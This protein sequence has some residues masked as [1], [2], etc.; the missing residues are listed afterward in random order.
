MVWRRV[1]ARLVQRVPRN[2]V[3]PAIGSAGSS[4][5]PLGAAWA[6]RT[7][8]VRLA[9]G[10][11]GG[12][13]LAVWMGGVAVELDEARSADPLG[14]GVSGARTTA[15]VYAAVCRAFNRRLVIDI[16]AGASAG[17]LNGAFLAGVI[18]HGKRLEPDFLRGRWLDIGDFGTL[19]QPIED[20]KPVSIMQGG[21]FLEQLEQAFH[22]L[23]RTNDAPRGD[24]EVP[25]LLDVQVTNVVGQERCFVDDWGQSFYAIEYRAPM[26]FREWEHYTA[27]FLATAARASASFPGAFESQQ[28]PAALAVLGGLG[29]HPTWAIDGGLLEN[30]PIRPAIELIPYRQASGPVR[31]Y[32]CYVN[33]APT[34][35]H[36]LDKSRGQP[37]LTKVLGYTINLPR[38]GRVVDQL[39][40]LD[41][42]TRRTGLT[43]DAGLRLLAVGVE[44][45]KE[46]ATHLLPTYQVRRALLS[47]ENVLGGS[48]GSSGPGL[49]R[50]TL[51]QLTEDAGAAPGDLAAGSALL[52]WI[53]GSVDPPA[54]PVVWR[55]G[56]RTGQRVIQ[57]QLDVLRALLLT[58]TSPEEAAAVFSARAELDTAIVQL[59]PTL[60]AFADPKGGV[61]TAARRL[62]SDNADV[63]R[64]ALTALGPP[65]HGAAT[66]V[67]EHLRRSTATFYATLRQLGDGALKRANLPSR[68][69]LFGKSLPNELDDP[70]YAA[71][72]ALA[73]PIEVIRRSFADDF[74]IETAQALHV[75]QLTPLVPAP[76]FDR[77]GSGTTER[78][79]PQ[80][81]RDKLAGVRLNHFAGFYRQSW[82]ANDFMWGRFDGATV[83]ARLLID[84]MRVRALAAAGGQP[85][86]DL[87]D[88]LVPSKKGDAGSAAAKEREELLEELLPAGTD[89][90][91]E[92]LAEALR[93]DL[94]EQDGELTRAVVARALQYAI[95]DTE[96][97][98]LLDAV[99]ADRAAGAYRCA[100]D[101]PRTGSRKQVIDDLRK[102]RDQRSLPSILGAGDP[103]E[104][105]S[106]LALRTIS[107]TVLVALAALTGIVPLAR[108]LH[109]ARVPFLAIRGATALRRLDRAAVVLGF[110]GAAWFVAARLLTLSH[111]TDDQGA[112]DRRATDLVPLKALWSSPVLAYGVSILAVLALFSIPLIR[113]IRAGQNTK[114]RVFHGSYALG[115]LLAGG[116]VVFGYQLTQR[117]VAQVL[118]TWDSPAIAPQWLLI[119]VVT[120]GAVQVAS[121]FGWV[122]QLLGFLH[123]PIKNR[124]SLTSLVL[125]LVA[126][127]LAYY[128][129]RE[130]FVPTWKDGTWQKVG[131]VLAG[132]AP[133][134][135]FLYLRLWVGEPKRAAPPSRSSP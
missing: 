66:E 57:L 80:T 103:S 113:T 20:T 7:E 94:L 90:L 128:C 36:E 115:F 39:Q 42:A 111:P 131:I 132:L 18:A 93:R 81:T 3:V 123:R 63:R 32:V 125:G 71:F 33:A 121:S 134:L 65:T 26:K 119:S 46:T 77:D 106:Q 79:G 40:A 118:T 64:D 135:A 133:V 58:S 61:A 100:L 120:A 124:V 76:L 43:A 23:L 110:T 95:L 45:L 29:P 87:A 13:S 37:N 59:E 105:T 24:G 38:D 70:G 96:I 122:L 44:G 102:G 41:D 53:P 16:L 1:L 28:I 51:N 98:F 11:N 50:S 14:P 97:P 72:L 82:R 107:H 25:V 74:D 67:G 69:E 68:Q 30:A 86:Q 117:S 109:P 55:W 19:L 101:W 78:L 114:R 56:V 83:I 34:S 54:E 49:A 4:T 2:E 112:L 60:R 92:R 104:G 5:R 91:P 9:M 52:P 75:A 47:L 21:R 10:W 116:A 108:W 127:V 73:L 130:G 6:G 62:T 99:T 15:E 89:P 12:V 35:H 22:D 88:A 8:E 17:G 48:A 84:P 27:P 31:R 126:G 85:W 129:V